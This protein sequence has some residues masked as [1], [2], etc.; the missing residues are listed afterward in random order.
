MKCANIV[1]TT[2]VNGVNRAHGRIVEN[3][4]IVRTRGNLVVPVD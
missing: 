3:V 2:G 4:T 1:L